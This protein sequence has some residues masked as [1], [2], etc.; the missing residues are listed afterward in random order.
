MTEVWSYIFTKYS[1]VGFIQVYLWFQKY[2]ALQDNCPNIPNNGQDN[3]DGDDKG[4]VCD[5]DDDN[6]NYIDGKVSIIH[7]A[8]N[9]KPVP[10]TGVSHLHVV[11]FGNGCS[12]K[13]NIR[14]SHF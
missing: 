8:M 6:D 10:C 9:V 5:E 1:R 2:I 14:W 13:W 3:N 11:L 12:W 7:F 4:D